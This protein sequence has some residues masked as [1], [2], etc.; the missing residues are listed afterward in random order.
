M[1]TSQQSELTYACGGAKI[2]N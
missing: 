1:G 2:S